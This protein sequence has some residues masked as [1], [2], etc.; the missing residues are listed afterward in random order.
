MSRVELAFQL[1]RRNVAAVLL[2]QTPCHIVRSGNFC[3]TPAFLKGHMTYHQYQ[4]QVADSGQS[5]WA[6]PLAVRG[7]PYP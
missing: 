6:D 1:V 4:Q 5:G 3:A 2:T 7:H